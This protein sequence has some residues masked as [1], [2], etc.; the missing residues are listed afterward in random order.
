MTKGVSLDGSD[1]F[2]GLCLL[3]VLGSFVHWAMD[4]SFSSTGGYVHWNF[5]QYGYVHWEAFLPVGFMSLRNLTHLGHV[6]LIHRHY[7]N[8]VAVH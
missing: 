2:R 4:I 7:V 3:G 8:Q 6:F 5:V 1:C